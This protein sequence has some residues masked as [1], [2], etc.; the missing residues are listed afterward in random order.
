MDE[1]PGRGG[2]ESR[3]SNTPPAFFNVALLTLNLFPPTSS[4]TWF[5]ILFSTIPLSTLIFLGGLVLVEVGLKKSFSSS[6]VMREIAS[7]SRLKIS[8]S[9]LLL[10]VALGTLICSTAFGSVFRQYS[11]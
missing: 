4:I 3:F 2:T 5:C 6:D 10:G 8:R 9:F 7:S 11:L 1:N